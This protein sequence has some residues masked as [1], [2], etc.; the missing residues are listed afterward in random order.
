[1]THSMSDAALLD[2]FALLSF[3]EGSH[4]LL[5]AGHKNGPA[6]NKG[7]LHRIKWKQIFLEIF[8]AYVV[9]IFTDFIQVF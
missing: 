7:S 1:M 5:V 3:L 6:T 9:L 2:L 4:L 8:T